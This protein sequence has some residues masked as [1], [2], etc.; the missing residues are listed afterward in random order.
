M[1]RVVLT[2]FGSYGDL[3]PYV[4]MAR[5]LKAHGDE[6]TLV[7]H[8]EYREVVE[9]AGVAFVPAPPGLDDLGSE[10]VWAAQAND[11]VR[12]LDFIARRLILPYLK[13][14]Y[15]VL[16]DATRGCD[17]I[18]SHLLTF[19]AP[20]VAQKRGIPWLSC[21]LQP[22]TFFSAH[23]PPALSPAP[24]LPR[25]RFLGPAFFRVLSR[26]LAGAT[27]KWFAPVDELRAEAGLPAA[28][29]HPLLAGFSPHGTLALFPEA[30][31]SP[32]PDWPVNVRQVGFP[33]F[34]RESTGELSPGLRE[35]LAAGPA[36][37][38]FT[39]GTA[40]VLM[41]TPFFEIAYRAAQEAGLRAVFLVGRKARGLPSAAAADPRVFV[42]GYEPFSALFPACRVLVHQCGIG[43]T[44]Q[45]LAAGRPQVPVPFAHDQPDNARRVCEL[46]LGVTVP[47]NRLSVRRLVAAL[48][49]VTADPAYLENAR[50]F[51][52]KLNAESFPPRLL[53]AVAELG[54]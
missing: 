16:L 19:A 1:R 26:S 4:G 44:A 34:D 37:A 47:A 5:V 54:G 33:L 10:A 23:D 9:S 53:A 28:P 20:L 27:R 17:L 32:Q 30:F 36:P 7:T 42:S 43:T 38:V 49:A 45:A 52:R 50:A 48:H 35:F 25:L 14:H 29:A 8:P 39:L 3:H 22:A 24:W 15:R 2:T 40:I 11:P 12:G 31:A 51:A 6:V 21:V 18:L 41:E 13:D 46:G